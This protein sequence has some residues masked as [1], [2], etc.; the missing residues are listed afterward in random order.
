MTPIAVAIVNF[1][2]RAHLRTCLASVQSEPASEVVVVDN[3]SS[4]GSVEMVQNEYPWVVLH[5]NATNLGYGAAA[6]QAITSCSAKYALLLNSDTLVSPGTLHALSSY[7]DLHPRAAVVGP[8]V[9]NPDGTLQTSC[10]PFPTPLNVFLLESGLFRLIRLFPVLRNHCLPAWPHTHAR[11]V[12]WMLGAV[13]AIRREAFAAVGGFDESFFMYSEEVDLCYRLCRAGWQ[14]HFTPD[15]VIMHVEGASTRQ[16]RAAMRAQ[17]FYSTKHFYR[18]HY[19]RA[20]Q[21][22]LAMIMKGTVLARLIR[23]AARLLFIREAGRRA[24]ITEDV[25]LWQRML[26][27]QW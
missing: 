26:L 20:R 25:A 13:L 15:T 16:Q 11:V 10:Y 12:P 14:A 21:A 27:G 6:N 8:R 2:T 23:D 1:N 24:R 17:V 22:E 3:A 9:V 4:D 19:S 5:A 7:L 18:L